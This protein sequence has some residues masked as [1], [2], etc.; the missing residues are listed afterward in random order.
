MKALV[1]AAGLGTRIAAFGNTQCKGMLS[2]HGKPLVEYSLD[3][4]VTAGVAEIVIVISERAEMIRQR[5]GTAYHGITIRY[6]RQEVPL[7]LVHAIEVGTPL[8]DGEDFLLFLSDEI[9]IGA[10]HHGMVRRFDGAQLSVICGVLVDS[11]PEA[12]CQ[13][14]DVIALPDRRIFRLVE[15]PVMPRGTLLGLGN[16]IF[17]HSVLRHLPEVPVNPNRGQ[18]DLTDLIQCAID[19]G[20]GVEF[21]PLCEQYVNVNTTADFQ[22]AQRMLGTSKPSYP[23]APAQLG[24]FWI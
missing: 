5:Y 1:L 8:L 10:D 22:R 13:N 2:I 24:N 17:K 7:G 4:A 15:K 21:F 18:K 19:A 16:C 20:E 6:V 12:I 3:N 11:S 9:L 23:P 14:Y